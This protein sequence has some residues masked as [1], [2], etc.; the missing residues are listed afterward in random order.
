[1]SLGKSK[2][3]YYNCL[4]FS[5]RACCPIACAACCLCLITTVSGSSK[6]MPLEE[7]ALVAG[8]TKL[9]QSRFSLDIYN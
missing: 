1:M 3:W 4:D 8:K 2:F 5:K 6:K 7:A 9:D